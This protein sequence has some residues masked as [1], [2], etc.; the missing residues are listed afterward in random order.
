VTAGVNFTQ[1]FVAYLDI[2]G[3]SEISNSIAADPGGGV[4]NAL[5][6]CHQNAAAIVSADATFSTAQFSDSIVVACTFAPTKLA[7]F[8]RVVADL[9]LFYLK[10][11]FLCRGGVAQ[12]M[13]YS[14]G[15]FLV[16]SGLVEAHKLEKSTARFPR[17]VVS[18]DLYDLVGESALRGAP[19]AKE[20]DGVY[21]IDYLGRISSRR[22]ASVVR[23][24]QSK[25]TECFSNSSNSVQEKGV[26]L[27]NYSDFRLGTSFSRARF[28]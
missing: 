23:A 25:V 19:L 12:G 6:R 15:S 8:C 21:F 13:H 16:S 24:V 3:F 22:K 11:G 5:Y 2:L 18:K 14:S 9:Q 7:K 28:E 20:D 1:S 26:W 27:A 10:E 17:V 4:L